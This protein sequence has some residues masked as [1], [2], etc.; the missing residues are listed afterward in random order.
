[1][2]RLRKI[3]SS[4]VLVIIILII[5]QAWWVLAFIYQ[6]A[7]TYQLTTAFT[8]AS[9]IMAIMIIN[10]EEDSGYQL[11]WIFLIMCVP[12][13]G[14]PLYLLAAGKRVP[15]KLAEETT[16]ASDRMLALLS[17]DTTTVEELKQDH[18]NVS[19]IFTY[20][21]QSSRYPVYT[22]TRARY[23]ASGESYWPAL[24]EQ[25]KKAEHFIFMEFF[26]IDQGE[27]WDSVLEVLKQKVQEGVEV[28]MVYDDFGCSTTLPANYDRQLNAWG[29]ETYRFNKM[30]PTLMIQMNNRDHRKIVVIDNKVGFTGGVN[31]ADEYVNRAS[32]FGY[33]KDSA[34]ML[35][36]EAVWSLTDMFLSMFTYVKPDDEDVD[37][38]RYHLQADVQGNYGY[39][40]PYSDTPTDD[41]DVALTMHL[42]VIAHARKYLY[43][44]TPYLIPNNDIVRALSVSAQSGVDVRIL[45]PHIPDKRYAFSIT[46]SNYHRLLKAGVRIYEFTPGFDHAKN[47]VS[48][49]TLGI[50]GTC[51]M[52]YRSYFLHFENGVLMY[53]SPEVVRLRQDFE[54]AIARSHEVTMEEVQKTNV[55]VRMFRGILRLLAPLF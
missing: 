23:F 38:S 19:K 8:I 31:L 11:S 34:I 7:M 21:F 4:R 13:I 50:V 44:D 45:V 42:N 26:I 6:N 48:D 3:L 14:I 53:R 1:M 43:V 33:W 20:A 10:R 28:K 41:K 54:Q 32:R 35:E 29:I 36:G 15:K 51:N 39:F 46:R 40:Q 9:I 22:N 25:L 5:L 24:L 37:Y 47:M 30:R 52:D 27:M 16:K 12:V 55:F 17:Q 49:D 18:P 2:Q